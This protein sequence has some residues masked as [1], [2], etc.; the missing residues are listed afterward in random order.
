MHITEY[1]INCLICLKSIWSSHFRFGRVATQSLKS[2][3]PSPW[4]HSALPKGYLVR[5]CTLKLS[6]SLCKSE[7]FV[8]TLVWVMCLH[9]YTHFENI[10]HGYAWVRGGGAQEGEGKRDSVWRT[11]ICIQSVETM[12][13]LALSLGYIGL[14]WV[15]AEARRKLPR[16]IWTPGLP[17]VPSAHWRPLFWQHAHPS[18]NELVWEGSEVSIGTPRRAHRPFPRLQGQPGPFSFSHALCFTD[19]WAEAALLAISAPMRWEQN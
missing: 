10:L 13:C 16:W 1:Y 17:T 15:G 7:V 19:S 2:A 12:M 4:K 6:F 14:W 3:H 11:H 8:C 5:P 9:L 18:A